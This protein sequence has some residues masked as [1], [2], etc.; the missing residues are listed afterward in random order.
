MR[1]SG[2]SL[3]SLTTVSSVSKPCLLALCQCLHALLLLL[4]AFSE[5]FHSYHLFCQLMATTI[6]VSPFLLSL[7]P[8]A[9]Q[10]WS[11]PLLCN[12]TMPSNSITIWRTLCSAQRDENTPH[13]YRGK[14]FVATCGTSPRQSCGLHGVIWLGWGRSW[15]SQAVVRLF[16]VK[17]S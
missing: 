9:N 8:S 2:I 5:E 12:W 15:C 13:H 3:L 4:C 14:G 17:R 11:Q 16:S 6:L 1:P 10:H 7:P